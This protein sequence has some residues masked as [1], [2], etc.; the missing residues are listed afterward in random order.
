MPLTRR[1]LAALLFASSG[2]V[3][4]GC[5]ESDAEADGTGAASAQGGG[6]SG[7]GATGASATGGAQASTGAGS[8]GAGGESAAH[9]LIAQGHVGRTLL[10]C[11][12]GASW[13]LDRSDDPDVRCEGGF[14][15]DHH[16][17]SATGIAASGGAVVMSSGWG[18]PGRVRRT[19]DGVT[20]DVVLDLEFPFAS[21]ASGPAGL[22]GAAPRPWLSTD[23]G[24]SWG[25]VPDVYLAPPLRQS[26]HLPLGD[27][28]YLLT[29]EGNGL[30]VFLTDDAGQS[31][32][33]A[34]P[35]PSGCMA[36]S[37]AYGNGTVAMQEVNGGVCLSSDGGVTWSVASVGEGVGF[38][39]LDFVGGR[40]VVIGESNG[41][42][43][44]HESP[45][46][47]TWTATPT[48]LPGATWNLV[49]GHN[50]DSGTLVAVSGSYEEQRFF[51]SED[52][53]DWTETP[54]APGG[55]PILR[56]LSAAL[57]S[58]ACR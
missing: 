26:I 33:E 42:R 3:V 14:D 5:V 4:A 54:A 31:F 53:L 46:A 49:L 56:F 36:I 55:H 28:R 18:T 11:D 15:C 25:E 24:G 13:V 7:T 16:V 50:A 23:S 47:Q 6:A 32:Q 44:L 30:R 37:F 17:G 35:L 10:S 34:S 1:Y 41:Q 57:A 52:G 45:D 58:P 8:G 22:M 19:L 20:W 2:A 48:N 40:F 51:R 38:R 43:V 9:V 39:T 27:G 21:I 29:S 12:D